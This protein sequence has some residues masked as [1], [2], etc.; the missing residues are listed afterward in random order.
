MIERTTVRLL[1][2]LLDRA[3]RKA[4]AFGTITEKRAANAGHDAGFCP[5]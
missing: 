3:R 1:K 4:A 2:D 5:L